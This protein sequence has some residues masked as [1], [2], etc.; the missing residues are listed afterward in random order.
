MK[1]L[2]REESTNKPLRG[3]HSRQREQ[4]VQS[5]EV[6][7]AW[8]LSMVNDQELFIPLLTYLKKV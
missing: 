6:G 5:L 8:R 1:N 2:K 3:G 7:K 4:P